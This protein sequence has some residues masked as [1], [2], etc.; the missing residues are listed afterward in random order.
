MV[1]G[2]IIWFVPPIAS[3]GEVANVGNIALKD[4]Y[5]DV[6]AAPPSEKISIAVVLNYHND[7]ELDRL[8]ELQSDNRSLLYR[9]WLSPEEFDAEFAPTVADDERVITSLRRAGF[10]VTRLSPNRTVIDAYGTVATADRYFD[11]RI[12]RVEQSGYGIRHANVGRAYLSS[13][14]KGIVF[15]IAGLTNIVSVQSD[16]ARVSSSDRRL[17]D[18][19]RMDSASGLTGP[20][21]LATGLAGYG[22]LAF[23]AGY[24]LPVQHSAQD[25]GRGRSVGIVINS[26]YYNSDLATFLK[27]FNVKRTGPAPVRV[28]IDGA[29]HGDV[30]NPETELDASAVLSTA[31][32]AQLYAYIMPAFTDKAIV[33]AY[34]RVVADNKVD[35]VNSSFGGCE[36]DDVTLSQAEDHIAK[37]GVALGIT[38]AA[39]SGDFGSS[40][41]GSGDGVSAPASS[42]HFVAVGGTTFVVNE[43]GQ[44]GGETGWA[45][46]GGGFSAV[47]SLPSWQ[48]DVKNTLNLGRN[49]PDVAFD[50][51]PYTGMAFYYTGVP[52]GSGAPCMS[53]WN[54]CLDPIGGTS[55]A[56]P[57]FAAMLVQI[58]E[59]QKNRLGLVAPSIYQLWKTVGYSVSGKT[60]FHDIVT[61]WNGNS[62]YDLPGYN[63]K[64]GYDLVT[65]IGSVDGWNVAGA[66]RQ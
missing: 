42:P 21:S 65:G 30:T 22:P 31:P 48:H 66:L 40:E 27:Y 23:T 8:I 33:D 53:G 39:A 29:I 58:E 52:P 17:R 1:L 5:R 38:F 12:D 51:D 63:A 11:T 10:F 37:Q 28:M 44:Y 6:G 50:A 36:L 59:V 32:G 18:R 24:D 43:N 62:I 60:Y 20:V 16:I 19:R 26:D 3:S 25:D 45:G 55:L 56:S 57:L 9:R 64:V 54:S 34:D 41:C 7:V 2:G 4:S 14:L 47:F 35:V 13:E 46:S 49:V 61:G 15:G